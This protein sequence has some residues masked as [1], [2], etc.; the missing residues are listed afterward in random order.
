MVWIYTFQWFILC[1][2]I[3]VRDSKEGNISKLRD[4]ERSRWC[5]KSYCNLD[6]LSVLH[7]SNIVGC[8]IDYPLLKQ[9]INLLIGS[10]VCLRQVIANLCLLTA[11]EKSFK[12]FNESCQIFFEGNQ[13]FDQ[14]YTLGTVQGSAFVLYQVQ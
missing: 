13:W 8:L 6:F 11:F 12:V 4:K 10:L 2:N 3:P 9:R 5:K 7:Q 1:V 14:P